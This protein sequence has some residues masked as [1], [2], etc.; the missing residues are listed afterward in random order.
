MSIHFFGY[1]KT[2]RSR[3]FWYPMKRLGIPF[4]WAQLRPCTC[5][6]LSILVNRKLVFYFQASKM[7]FPLRIPNLFTSPQI[8]TR[9]HSWKAVEWMALSNTALAAAHTTVRRATMS[10][11]HFL[12]SIHK[13]IIYFH[14]PASPFVPPTHSSTG[15]SD[16]CFFSLP[17]CCSVL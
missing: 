6:M 9:L 17:V 12:S 4:H 1:L 8:L 2:S 7:S 13:L 11:Q 16:L 14:L 3:W 15:F 10:M 5:S